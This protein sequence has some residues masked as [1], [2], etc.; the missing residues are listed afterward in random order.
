MVARGASAAGSGDDVAAFMA[1]CTHP[2]LAVIEALRVQL[3]ALDPTVGEAIKWN[4]PSFHTR[5]HFATLHLR[6]PSVVQLILHRGAKARADALHVDDPESLLTW[7]GPERATLKFVTLAELQARQL[8]LN[9]V[10]RQWI[11][12]V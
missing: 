4:A 7:L 8:A 12:Q 3:K 1:N 5:E 2:L 9:A 10:L 6:D 11:A